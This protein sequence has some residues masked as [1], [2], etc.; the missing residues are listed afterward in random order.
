MIKFENGIGQIEGRVP[1]ILHETKEILRSVRKMLE[2]NM[3]KEDA[4]EWINKI[5]RRSAMTEKEE[6]I[7]SIKGVKDGLKKLKE[8][9]GDE[10][11]SEDSDPHKEQDEE[12]MP[13]FLGMLLDVLLDGDGKSDAEGN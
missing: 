8:K 13:D 6:I 7:D 11:E 4:D 9:L 12:P 3:S 10:K 1:L 2:E 5:V